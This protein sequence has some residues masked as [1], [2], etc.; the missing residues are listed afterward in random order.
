MAVGCEPQQ[1]TATD[2]QQLLHAV[3]EN[4]WREDTCLRHLTSSFN[5]QTAAVLRGQ[6]PDTR[7]HSAGGGGGGGG[8]GGVGGVGGLGGG[9]REDTCL[10]HLTVLRGQRPKTDQL[11]DAASIVAVTFA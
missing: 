3:S 1:L 4:G 5:P 6:R 7:L 9:W 2:Q 11:E 10:R 8:G